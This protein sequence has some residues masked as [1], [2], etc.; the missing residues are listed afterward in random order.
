M[1]QAEAAVETA[2]AQLLFARKETGRVGALQ[3]S[4]AVT[5]EQYDQKVAQQISAQAALQQA[6]AAVA[7]A[8]LNLTFCH[9]TAPFTGRISSHR[10]S[11]G[12]LVMG[13]TTA[14]NSTLLTTLVSLDPIH[15]D[16]QMSEDDYLSYERYIHGTRGAD[17]TVQAELSDQQNYPLR[18]TLD[19]IDN[20]IDPGTGTI[21]ARATFAN[22]DLFTTPG[23]FGQLRLPTSAPRDVLLVP[24]SALAADQSNEVAMTVAANNTG[25]PKIVQTG[26]VNDGLRQITAGLLPHDR[27]II[28]GLMLAMPGTKVKPVAGRISLDAQN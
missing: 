20:E 7:S 8:Q 22:H 4:G 9:I 18:G 11:V 5:K 23:A 21:H 2:Q 6:E 24:D 19:F 13:G 3:D 17:N 14:G 25:V 1:Q 28:D 12:D 15:F 27:V 10:V 26:P 16:F